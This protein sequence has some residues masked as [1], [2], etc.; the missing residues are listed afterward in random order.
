MKNPNYQPR[1]ARENESIAVNEGSYLGTMSYNQDNPT[2]PEEW[3]GIMDGGQVP[4]STQRQR[5]ILE[6]ANDEFLT[7]THLEPVGLVPGVA[8]SFS[9]SRQDRTRRGANQVT[10]GWQTI[11]PTKATNALELAREARENV[12]AHSDEIWP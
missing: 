12:V 7:D 10:P 2:L 8:V 6:Y 3:S 5:A 9:A 4:D 11:V 1:G